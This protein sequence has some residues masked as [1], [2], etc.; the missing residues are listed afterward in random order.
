MEDVLAD[1]EAKYSKEIFIIN[2]QLADFASEVFGESSTVAAPPA[3]AAPA[4]KGKA[5]P[6]PAAPAAA[7]VRG[8]PRNILEKQA[9][10]D[11]WYKIMSDIKQTIS[12]KFFIEEYTMNKFVEKAQR[13]QWE[14][15]SNIANLPGLIWGA[16]NDLMA[17]AW[18]SLMWVLSGGQSVVEKAATIFTGTMKL[19]VATAAWAYHSSVQM[20]GWTA[21]KVAD[22]TVEVAKI[23]ARVVEGAGK[24]AWAVISKSLEVLGNMVGTAINLAISAGN[25]LKDAAVALVTEVGNLLSTAAHGMQSF[26]SMVWGGLY[27]T[28]SGVLT[29][30]GSFAYELIKE[31]PAEVALVASAC[32]AGLV[33]GSV[34]GL[35]WLATGTL[36]AGMGALA[37]PT[38]VYTGAYEEA[39]KA[40][41]ALGDATKGTAVGALAAAATA[42]KEGEV[43]VKGSFGA[44]LW[45]KAFPSDEDKKRN[46][47]K[48]AVDK[49]T[50]AAK[51]DAWK[52]LAEFEKKT[53]ADKAAKA[54]TAGSP[55]FGPDDNVV[56][57]RKSLESAAAAAAGEEKVKAYEALAKFE[58]DQ[59]DATE[60]K[61]EQS[62]KDSAKYK[63]L[64][65][66]SMQAAAKALA[67]LNKE[68]DPNM[69]RAIKV[70]AEEHKTE[71]KAELN[72][73]HKA[74][75]E[76]K[77]SAKAP[78]AGPVVDEDDDNEI[79]AP[80]LPSADDIK[81]KTQEAVEQAQQAHDKESEGPAKT[82]RKHAL[83]AAKAEKAAID[84]EADATPDAEERL[85][86]LSARH[87]RVTERGAKA[88]TELAKVAGN[89]EK[90]GEAVKKLA[91]KAIRHHE[92]ASHIH[93]GVAI[94]GKRHLRSDTKAGRA[95]M[96]SHKAAHK[97]HSKKKV[98]AHVAVHHAV[99]T[100]T[101]YK[102][103]H[104]KA[105]PVVKR[106]SGKKAAQAHARKAAAIGWHVKT[107]IG[108]T[109]SKV[110][111]HKRTA[112]KKSAERKQRRSKRT[113]G[114]GQEGGDPYTA[115][116]KAAAAD[117]SAVQTL[118]D[119]N[120]KEFESELQAVSDEA[121]SFEKQL[122]DIPDPEVDDPTDIAFPAKSAPPT[123]AEIKALAQDLDPKG[124]VDAQV[125]K[126]VAA[127]GGRRV[128]RKGGLVMRRNSTR[129]RSKRDKTRVHRSARSSLNRTMRIKM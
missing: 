66:G 113:R 93:A 2:Q 92:N 41:D 115:D 86:K 102:R 52:A 35:S 38:T 9:D 5:A 51:A 40:L 104:E 65:N 15:W 4:A 82:V 16:A 73:A 36:M 29:K 50:G 55:A 21:A 129:R 30:L 76:K 42:K 23:G 1:L 120:I 54:A 47:L 53:E 27:S 69:R 103:A 7:P 123:D 63:S 97:E 22:F 57:R 33:V 19:G 62:I 121:A 80:T 117:A 8:T 89:H 11:K 99:K 64:V 32:G 18:S 114:G 79:T 31:H 110:L 45:S 109:S 84:A 48:A 105:L 70:F 126:N 94:E 77:A 58:K 67:E 71:I 81:A 91:A 87:K 90:H 28:V 49:A 83:D 61:R 96:A 13:H 125:S 46:E 12:N 6:A 124:L 10:N 78:A 85:K 75:L 68:K 107:S 127:V 37:A 26:V 3:A 119:T 111:A 60:A 72:K 112:M 34:W 106:H 74:A 44:A 39:S 43:A 20:A 24:V 17:S 128:T 116:E 122:K 56:Q 108:H 59:A 100:A 118:V 101:K 25:L 14:K 98:D 88:H 95:A